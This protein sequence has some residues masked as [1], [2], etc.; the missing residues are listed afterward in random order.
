[1]GN[2]NS[3]V[4]ADDEP[5]QTLERRDLS[6]VAKLIKDG[7]AKRIVVMTGAGIST[8]AGIPDFRSPETGL[9]HNLARL[10]LPYAE[11]VFDIDYFEENPYPFYVLAKELYPGRFHPTIAHVFI[12]LLAKKKL[13]RMLFTQN[14]DC[15][16]RAA[17]V[18][19]D[20]IVEAHGS[21]ATQRCI[22]CK[23]EYPDKEMH[24]HVLEGKPPKCIDGCGGLVKPDIVFF[25]EQLPATFYNNRGQAATAD[26]ML[27]LGTSLTVHPFASLPMM[28]MEGVPRV[29]FN[30]ERVGDMGT[31]ADDVICLSDCD[32]GIRQLAEELGWAEELSSMWR[33]LV[34]NTEA[35]RQ[36]LHLAESRNRDE[37]RRL[38][39][40]VADRL[41][42]S[43]RDEDGEGANHS[44]QVDEK[45]AATGA[46]KGKEEGKKG[47]EAKAGQAEDS[48]RPTFGSAVEGDEDLYPDAE[49]ATPAQQKLQE[50]AEPGSGVKTEKGETELDQETASYSRAVADMADEGRTNGESKNPDSVL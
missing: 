10:N 46:T 4:I 24:E 37:V 20:L 2:E 34:G 31:R 28:A 25:G 3:T 49:K 21:F 6:S 14:I 13:L 32:S 9:Y 8:A 38:A 45:E 15:L 42:L 23:T 11:A 16:E 7:R 35:D 5:T 1:M 18:P 26:L 41:E 47:Q 27:V 19:G 48:Q 30:K 29:L 12:A 22:K 44:A 39:D 43:D 33:N 36:I 17:G 50:S 40:E